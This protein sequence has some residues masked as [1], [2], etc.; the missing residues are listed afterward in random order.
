VLHGS[1]DSLVWVEGGRSFVA[2]LRQVSRRPVAY[3]E[4]PGAHHAFDIF[5]SVRCVNAVNGVATF[6]AWVRSTGA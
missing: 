5:Q 4:F 6:L 3:A 2:A 1:H